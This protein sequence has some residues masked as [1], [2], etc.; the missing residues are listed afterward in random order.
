M[1]DGTTR[2]SNSASVRD[3]RDFERQRDRAKIADLIRGRFTERYIT[4]IEA[5]RDKK[6]GF[7]TMAISCLM[8]EALESFR[9]GWQNTRGAGR[10]ECAFRSFFQRHDEFREIPADSFYQHV[11]CGILHQAETTGGWRIVRKGPIFDSSSLTLNATKFHRALGDILNAYCSEL[12]KE[13]WE[14]QLWDACRK[15]MNAVI[16]N[17]SK[18]S[19]EETR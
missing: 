14:S 3:Y 2:L 1:S 9:Q 13:K 8:I 19:D 12:A 11:R 16:K 5:A 17:C 4:P 18:S 10:C 15:K 7:C 6:H